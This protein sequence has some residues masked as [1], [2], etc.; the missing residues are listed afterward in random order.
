[1]PVLVEQ[2][3]DAPAIDGRVID[4]ETMVSPR[5]TSLRLRRGAV[6]HQ[7]LAASAMT[8]VGFIIRAKSR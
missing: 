8:R 1:V 3:L 7:E 6:A 2:I 5:L 4:A